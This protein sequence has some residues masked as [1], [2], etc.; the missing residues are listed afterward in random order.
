MQSRKQEK[1]ARAVGQK[2]GADALSVDI[3]LDGGV[4]EESAVEGDAKK[5]KKA[6]LANQ[7][8]ETQ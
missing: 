6:G 7:S 4:V 3:V 5:L 1:E 8:C 2:R